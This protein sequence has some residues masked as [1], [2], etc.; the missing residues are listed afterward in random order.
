MSHRVICREVIKGNLTVIYKVFSFCLLSTHSSGTIP[1]SLRTDILSSVEMVW[2]RT[3]VWTNDCYFIPWPTRSA[4]SLLGT[5]VEQAG[6]ALGDQAELR[7][8]CHAKG[9]R[10]EVSAESLH[11]VLLKPTQG[12]LCSN[13]AS[14]VTLTLPQNSNVSIKC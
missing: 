8:S 3:Q 6:A 9:S 13:Y 1:T 7:M 10:N 14:C 5:R 11:P 4:P 2:V 12:S